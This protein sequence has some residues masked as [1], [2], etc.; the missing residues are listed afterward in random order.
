MAA[1][2]GLVLGEVLGAGLGDGVVLV[3][4]FWVLLELPALP[5]V[6][7]PETLPD[8]AAWMLMFLSKVILK[9]MTW[10]RLTERQV[11]ILT[12]PAPVSEIITNPGGQGNWLPPPPPLP[13]EPVAV[14]VL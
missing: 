7:L 8:W 5:L 6:P 14:N 11:K 10:L 2:D 13:P 9:V 3:T 4:V 12:E 1:G